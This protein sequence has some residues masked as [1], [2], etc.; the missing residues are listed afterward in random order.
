MSRHP[1]SVRDSSVNRALAKTKKGHC[2]SS[3]GGPFPCPPLGFRHL[4]RFKAPVWGSHKET[5]STDPLFPLRRWVWP[6]WCE[7]LVTSV[8]WNEQ[9]VH[10][11]ESGLRTIWELL[12]VR[13]EL[14]PN[15]WAPSRATFSRPLEADLSQRRVWTQNPIAYNRFQKCA[16][17]L[18][19]LEGN[20]TALSLHGNHIG[21]V[22][23]CSQT[24]TSI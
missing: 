16:E 19:G 8:R 15:R 20:R 24:R 7:K 10:F 21:F 17:S 18:V 22:S 13:V 3:D 4:V 12:W 23:R 5:T 1:R 2:L 14:Q 6:G 9:D 11:R